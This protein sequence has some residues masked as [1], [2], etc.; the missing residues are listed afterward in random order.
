MEKKILIT[1]TTGFVGSKLLNSLDNAIASP[2]LRGA[3]QEDIKRIIE[4]SDAEII[5]HTAA[6]SDIGECEADHDASN[7]ANVLIPTYIANASK[8]RK[9]I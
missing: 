9:L 6:I 7:Y 5:I 1:G 4:E 3:T 2:S 8:G